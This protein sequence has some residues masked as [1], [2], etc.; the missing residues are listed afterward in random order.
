MHTLFRTASTEGQPASARSGRWR[1]SVIR[2]HG[3]S[4]PLVPTSFLDQGD[5]FD[6]CLLACLP[7]RHTRLGGARDKALLA[8]SAACC[9]CCCCCRRRRRLRVH[10]GLLSVRLIGCSCDTCLHLRIARLVKSER[11]AAVDLSHSTRTMT[12]VDYADTIDWQSYPPDYVL[13]TTRIIDSVCQPLCSNWRET[14][15][16]SPDSQWSIRVPPLNPQLPHLQSYTEF[17]QQSTEKVRLSSLY[18]YATTPT[19]ALAV[20]STPDAIVAVL[21]LVLCLRC[22]KSV[23]LPYFKAW[24]RSAAQTTHGSA[25]LDHNPERIDKFGEYVFRLLFHT[26]ISIYGLYC[27]AGASWWKD[28]RELFYEYPYQPVQVTEIWYYLFQSAYNV[29]ALVSIFELSFVVRLKHGIPRIQWSPTV[30]GDFREMLAHHIITNML[31]L[32]SSHCRLTRVGN[33]VC[34]IHDVS[35]IPVDL[36]KLANFLKYKYT[37]LSCFLLMMVTWAY[38]RL[39]LL[40]ACL[41]R[42][43]LY[44]SHYLCSAGMLNPT[45]YLTFR[46]VFQILLFLLL[47]LHTVW[48]GM[49]LRI[50]WTFVRKQ[51]CHDLSEHKQGEVQSAMSARRVKTRRIESY[52]QDEKKED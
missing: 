51:E 29:D 17:V 6:A 11:E 47:V 19:T 15:R 33:L 42:A 23:C 34:L 45:T 21:C 28:T 39:Y 40:P 12:A 8:A 41:W 14:L 38:T 46:K 30:R 5:A 50:L 52:G 4:L 31:V 20:S 3:A 37:T 16:L 9:C 25:W 13:W 22:I 44:E 1:A 2:L 10:K 27:F 48:F 7:A 49:F 35:D 32:G 36:S 18:R 24:G 43:C 26:S